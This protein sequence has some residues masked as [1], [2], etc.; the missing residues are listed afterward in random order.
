MTFASDRRSWRNSE[1]GI[2]D[3]MAEVGN[4]FEFLQR[5]CEGLSGSGNWQTELKFRRDSNRFA[6]VS[7][8]NTRF[9]VSW[10]HTYG[11]TL[12]MSGLHIILTEGGRFY[13]NMAVVEPT[14]IA[15]EEYDLDCDR[16]RRIGWRV[17]SGKKPFHTSQQLADQWIRQLLDCI[18][19]RAVGNSDQ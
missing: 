10:G 16:S 7:G 6:E 14:Q 12:D 9:S 19:R 2:Q 5:A 1:K 8:W 11:N 18:R 17:Q 4:L 15:V 13:G 3:A